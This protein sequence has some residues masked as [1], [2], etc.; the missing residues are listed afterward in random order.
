MTTI[1]IEMR[2]REHLEKD[3][4][5]GPKFT[6]RLSDSEATRLYSLHVRH[7]QAYNMAFDARAVE[8]GYDPNNLSDDEHHEVYEDLDQW[9]PNEVID[10]HKADPA[11]AVTLYLKRFDELAAQMQVIYDNHEDYFNSLPDPFPWAC[12]AP[13]TAKGA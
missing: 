8:L 12:D 13:T 3:Y 5:Y 6:A 2:S 11:R 10:D 1:A 9:D 4:N 7:T